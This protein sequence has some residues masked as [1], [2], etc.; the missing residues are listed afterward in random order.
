MRETITVNVARVSAGAGGSAG[1]AGGP[2][3]V[4]ATAT[5]SAG[6]AVGVSAGVGVPSV[7]EQVT[8]YAE[9]PAP[10]STVDQ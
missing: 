9:A 4:V 3:S 2:G 8:L 7:T 5:A 10:G 1:P 6:V